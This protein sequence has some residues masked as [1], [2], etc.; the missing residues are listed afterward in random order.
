[1][2]HLPV[3]QG[4]TDKVAVVTGG[5]SGI[6]AAVAE[7]LRR[8]GARVE[9]FDIGPVENAPTAIPVDVTDA[10]SVCSAVDTMIG[11][12]GRCDIV[13]NVAGV[14]ATGTVL[15]TSD[16]DWDRLLAVNV[17]GVR[18]VCRALLPHLPSGSAIVNVA[19]AAGVRP[20]REMAAYATTKAAVVALTKAMAVD[21][22]D[23]GVRVNC[24]CPGLVDTPMLRASL[25]QRSRDDLADVHSYA[26][27][28]IKR[29][30]APDEIAAGVAFLASDSASYI[31]GT[32]LVID[33]GRTLH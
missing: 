15:A 29:S 32:T 4:L 23:A 12:L 18:N 24:V 26:N 2:H 1:M 16:R 21:H 11:Q 9:I 3:Q 20:N 6:G 14:H 8:S 5:A 17:G 10:E 22:A 25:G 13:V 19:S 28:L 30:A 31:T 7:C 27:Y 33:G